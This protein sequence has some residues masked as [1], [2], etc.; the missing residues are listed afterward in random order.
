MN[1][2]EQVSFI[3]FC[4]ILI[5][6]CLGAGTWMYWSNKQDAAPVQVVKQL[7]PNQETDLGN[8][9]TRTF[10]SKYN[11]VCYNRASGQFSC[12]KAQ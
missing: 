9:I 11:V 10:D 7:E 12:V 2:S 1:P 5:A 6:V 3:K 4:I 8:R